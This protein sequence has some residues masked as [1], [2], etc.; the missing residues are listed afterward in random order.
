MDD[1]KTIGKWLEKDGID[2]IAV[3]TGGLIDK[4]PNIHA[5]PGLYHRDERSQFDSVLSG[6]LV[7]QSR[8]VR[9][10]PENQ[11]SRPDPAR[12]S[13]YQQCQLFGGC[14]RTNPRH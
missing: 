3:S 14:I 2:C 10:H 6:R 12:H 9:T 13:A 5:R 1:W 8:P 7:G 11:P 4:K